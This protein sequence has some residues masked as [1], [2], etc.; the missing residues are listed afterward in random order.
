MIRRPP[1]STLFPYTTL[2]RSRAMEGLNQAA[3]L[4]LVLADQTLECPHALSGLLRLIGDEAAN[5]LQ[6]QVD[7]GERLEQAV[8][9]VARQTEPF[10]CHRGLLL[11]SHAIEVLHGGR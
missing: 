6:L 1:R 4:L 8:M 7:R 9:Q 10:F 3:Q 2:F 5:A 11:T